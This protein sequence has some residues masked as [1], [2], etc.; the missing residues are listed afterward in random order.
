MKEILKA[1]GPPGSA[2]FVTIGLTIGL[3]LLFV[4]P[5]R[6]KPAAMWLAI[7]A[8]CHVVLAL[9]VVSNFVADSLS[10]IQRMQPLDLARLLIV[11]QGNHAE[12][13]AREASRA[14]QLWPEA[15]VLVLGENWFVNRLVRN[16]VPHS[17]IRQLSGHATTLEQMEALRQYLHDHP[18]EPAAIV[19]SRVHMR[20]VTALADTMGLHLLPLSAP[21]NSEP[22][23]SGLAQWLPN[24][25]ALRLAG[26]ALYEY[27]ALAYYSGQGWI[28]GG[29]HGE[30]GTSAS[31]GDSVP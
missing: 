20:R 19:A 14:A 22:P 17:R 27:A 9:P 10:P 6:L 2:G 23:R 5:R 11:L 16:G 13:R 3:G 28:A 29:G 8:G 25:S 30:G 7:L 15:K 24:S 26:A 18:A 21:L 1:I 12:G 31:A 4:W